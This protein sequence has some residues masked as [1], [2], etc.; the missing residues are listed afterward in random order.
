MMG[1]AG[2]ITPIN[3]TPRVIIIITGV[4][5]VDAAMTGQIQIRYGIAP[6]PSNQGA[7]V[8]TSVGAA[9]NIKGSTGTGK[10]GF[11]LCGVVSG[12][13]SGVP[14]WIDVG[15]ARVTGTSAA[16]F[17]VDIVAIEA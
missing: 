13:T 11:A 6:V 12:L 8:G 15:L 5:Q 4:I 10:Q 3:A 9:K 1:L 2:S 14:Y 16:I 17:D 7:V